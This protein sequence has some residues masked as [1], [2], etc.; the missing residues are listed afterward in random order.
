MDSTFTGQQKK[1]TDMIIKN[2]NVKNADLTH[3][4]TRI[5]IHTNYFCNKKY[6]ARAL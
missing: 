6:N 1:D 2:V 3:T 4:H 5:H